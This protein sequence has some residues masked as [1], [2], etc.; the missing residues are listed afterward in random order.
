M[1]LNSK[2]SVIIKL[3]PASKSLVY[4]YCEVAFCFL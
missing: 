4:N 2:L 3:T 1:H